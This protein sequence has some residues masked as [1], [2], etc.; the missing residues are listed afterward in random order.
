MLRYAWQRRPEDALVALKSE[1][2]KPVWATP[3][4][5]MGKRMLKALVEE[6]GHDY[7]H[8]TQGKSCNNRVDPT[9]LL[10]LA[11]KQIS[12]SLIMSVMSLG[13]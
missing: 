10:E 12:S 3:G 1:M 11:I 13:T 5:Y 9:I 7:Q 4:R 2:G 8:L 6:L